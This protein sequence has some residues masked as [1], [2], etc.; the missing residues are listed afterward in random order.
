[1]SVYAFGI[2]SIR[3]A[4]H[5]WKGLK[6]TSNSTDLWVR[7]DRVHTTPM[8]WRKTPFVSEQEA[9]AGDAYSVILWVDRYGY[10]DSEPRLSPNKDNNKA[11]PSK[12]AVDEMVKL[13]PNLFMEGFDE[14]SAVHIL[15]SVFSEYSSERQED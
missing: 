10:R 8:G 13:W 9:K 14:D 12:K 2:Q 7:W 6:M 4:W 5:L 15:D 11:S 1:M 3:N